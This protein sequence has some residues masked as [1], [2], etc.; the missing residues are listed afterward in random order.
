MRTYRYRPF[1]VTTLVIAGAG[2][3]FGEPVVYAAATIPLAFV[4][5][6][7][8]AAPPDPNLSISRSLTPT[9]PAPG[10]VVDVSVTVMNE[11]ENTLTDLRVIDR[12]PEK[13][14]VTGGSPRESM[15][16]R[17]GDSATFSYE[18]TAKR[19]SHHFEPATVMARDA[20]GATE[21][22]TTVAAETT[23]ECTTDVPEVSLR[24][25]TRR[26]AG[27]LVTDEGGSGIEFHGIREYRYGDPVNRVDWRRFARSGELTTVEYREERAAAVVLCLDAREP[28]Y[29]AE[30]SDE[31][32]A[33]S[34]GRAAVERLLDALRETPNRVGIAALGREL[35]WLTPGTGTEHGSRA[36]QLLSTHPTLSTHPPNSGD[37]NDGDGQLT[38][39][40]TR[41]Q[42]DTQVVFVSP[43]TDEF[44]ANAVL[45]LEAAGHEVT[46][47]SPDVTADETAGSRLV[48]VERDNRLATL[49]ESGIPAVDWSPTEPLGAELVDARK[50]WS[51]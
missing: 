1:I 7:S 49:R 41:L 17:P 16:L 38:E 25:Q 37:A 39:L 51:A 26:V 22:E 3:A 47:V 42:T 19:G 18:V 5:V 23:I 9:D 6:D 10:E 27:Q 24:Q 36:E 34:Y 48:G 14:G 44:A 28:A 32:H 15:A 13:L 4:F 45:E 11:G 33:V 2:I 40:R 12:V 31:P 46:V 35:C 8:L 30:S 43:L 21:V 29:R 20:S 50:R